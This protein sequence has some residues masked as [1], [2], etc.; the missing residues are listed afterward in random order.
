MPVTP[1][2]AQHVAQLID[3]NL[4]RAR[5]GIRVIEDWCRFGLKRKDLVVTL[6]NLR[7]ELGAN[8]KDAYKHARSTHSDPGAELSHPFQQNRIAPLKVVCAN[9]ARAQEALRV[10]EEFSRGSNNQL[11]V[12]SSKIR[13]ELYS[14]EQEI[15]K[16]SN[17]SRLKD[18]LHNSKLC[19]V[20]DSQPTLI[21][22]V[23]CALKA[24]ITMVQYRSKEKTD[25]EKI[26]QAKELAAMCK[27]YN[28]LF[29]VND[30]IDLA[31]AVDA[32]GVHLGQEDF[33]LDDA[34]KVL[35][36]EKILG[37]ST[38]SI[39]QVQQAESEGWDYIG[40]GPIFK[41]KSKP[42]AKPIG[43]NIL[44]EVSK[45]THLPCFAIGGIS[46]RNIAEILATGANRIAIINAIMGA[47]D[48]ADASRNLLNQ[49]K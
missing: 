21:N 33:P 18:I 4:D 6:K 36:E 26:A 43:L 28:S 11:S 48:V 27:K 35:G 15:L 44:G 37:V 42:N 32:D 22:T 47:E 3:A 24:G 19:L 45:S 8:H 29:I 17:N 7:Q 10:I 12:I 30:R 39:E 38:H 49:L 31:I 9:C 41:S 14:V 40:I 23:N 16:A 1:K 25:I 5:E 13:Y 34:K 2:H 20:T 46:E